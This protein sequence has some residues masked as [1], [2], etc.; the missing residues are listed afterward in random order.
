M[1]WLDI[2]RN[3]TFWFKFSVI[4]LYSLI[5]RQRHYVSTSFVYKMYN[6]FK[7]MWEISYSKIYVTN[8]TKLKRLHYV[9][10]LIR[11]YA[12]ITMGLFD[13]THIMSF[14]KLMF[15]KRFRVPLQIFLFS[16]PLYSVVHFS[17]TSARTLTHDRNDSSKIYTNIC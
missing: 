6:C 14:K 2:K 11:K 10:L 4:S 17:M 12:L 5:Y 7:M 1:F 8:S 15:Q 13:N 16:N 9:S 3:L